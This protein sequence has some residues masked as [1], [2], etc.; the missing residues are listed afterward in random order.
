M[1]WKH[2]GTHWELLNDNGD[3]LLNIQ[4]TNGSWQITNPNHKNE[5]LYTRLHNLDLAKKVAIDHIQTASTET[6]VEKESTVRLET[7]A[8]INNKKPKMHK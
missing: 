1:K 3:P 7:S 5:I 4:P 2:T 8:E 6:P